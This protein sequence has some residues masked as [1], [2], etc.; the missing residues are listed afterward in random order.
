MQ[1]YVLTGLTLLAKSFCGCK[2]KFYNRKKVS[3]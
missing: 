1:F 2:G 3:S